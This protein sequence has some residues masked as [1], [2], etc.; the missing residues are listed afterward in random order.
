MATCRIFW[1]KWLLKKALSRWL[2]DL[3]KG[4]YLANFYVTGVLK[5]C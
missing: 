2:V 5:R 1:Q 4:D 3:R